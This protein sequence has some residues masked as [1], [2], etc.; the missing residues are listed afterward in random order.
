VPNRT[1]EGR[2]LAPIERLIFLVRFANGLAA[3][4]ELAINALRETRRLLAGAPQANHHRMRAAI[5]LLNETLSPR[6]RIEL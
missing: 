2:E 6:A 5:K 3:E 1:K 4:H